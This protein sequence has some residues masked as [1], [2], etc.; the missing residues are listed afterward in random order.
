MAKNKG[1]GLQECKGTF[2]IKGKVTGVDKDNFYREITTKTGKDMRMISFGVE[3]D[4]G[5]TA[6]ISLNGMERDNVYFSAKVD[7][8]TVVETVPWTQRKTFSKDGYRPIGIALGL[9]KIRNEK[10]DL[11]NEKCTLVEYDACKY[12]ADNLRDDMSVFVRGK[13]EYSEYNGKHQVKFIPAQISLC[14]EIDFNAENFEPTAMFEQQICFMGIEKAETNGEFVVSAKIIGY[15]SVEDAEFFMNKAS[16]A[17]NLRSLKPYTAIELGG[18]IEVIHD[19][20]T[21]EDDDGWGVSPMAALKNPTVRR[22]FVI[23]GNKDSI[24]TTIYSEKE[25]EEAIAKKNSDKVAM[26][27]YGGASD[28]GWGESSK[29]N[30]VEDDW[31]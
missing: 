8:K 19:V 1:L 17:K 25:I 3:F 9:T 20:V 10:G 23:A 11:V 27:D 5:K 24:D 31:D 28:D 30:E 21:E 16:L 14:S 26:V 22:L 4:K 18:N 15:N 6:Y 13:M 2:V 7:D 29:A 12:I